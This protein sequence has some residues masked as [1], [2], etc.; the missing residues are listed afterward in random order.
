MNEQDTLK[1]P[2]SVQIDK[3]HISLDLDN[4]RELFIVPDFDPFS[5]KETEYWGSQPW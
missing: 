2:G 1:D 3:N 4:I 5:V